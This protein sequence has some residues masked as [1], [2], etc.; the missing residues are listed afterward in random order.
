MEENIRVLYVDDEPEL[1]ELGR[2]FLE[3][4][5]IFRVDTAGSATE[6]LASPSITSCDVIVADYQMPDTDGIGFLKEVRS[7]FGP[8][9][10]ILFTGRGREEVVVDAINN[11]VDFYL[12]K[13]GDAQCQFAE[14]S[15]KIHQAVKRRRAEDE[16]IFFKTSVDQ[17]YDEVFWLEFDGTIRYVNEAACRTL[18][19]SREELTGMKIFALDPDFSPD[20]WERSVADL[21]IRKNQFILTR[22]RKKDGS[23]ID[24]EIMTTYLRKG[25]KEYSFAYV[26]DITDSNRAQAATVERAD[27]AETTFASI[28]KNNPLPLTIVSAVDGTMTDL[29]DAFSRFSGYARHEVIGRPVEDLGIIADRAAY[30]NFI[31]ELQEKGFVEGMDLPCRNREGHDRILRFTSTTIRYNNEPHVLSS[32]VDVTELH[33]ARDALGHANDKLRLLSDITRHDIKNKLMILSGFITL[34][35]RADGDPARLSELFEKEADAVRAINSMIAFARDYESVGIRAP[36]WQNIGRLTGSSITDLPVQ[37]IRVEQCDPALEVFSDPLLG[38]VFYNLFD[39]AL[40]YGGDKLTMIR[41]SHREDG[42]GLLLIVE[43]NGNGIAP[44]DKAKLFTRGYGK[45]TGLG[46]FLSREILAI[47]GITITEN[48]E[49]GSGAQFLIRVPRGMY[50]FRP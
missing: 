23:I 1:L 18:G 30:L 46:L 24:V 4:T 38:R 36:A 44:A 35:K 26:R 45:N 50:R 27:R 9:P 22:H 33:R 47:T 17:A 19:Y 21:R 42:D 5:G 25:E 20:V 49:P 34:A 12:Q 32:V 31:S 28:F 43:D 16:L 10:F 13:G 15:H 2:L 39:N 29:N 41:V 3:A 14:L 37:N 8:L 40:R 6:A 48:G 11:G 7:R